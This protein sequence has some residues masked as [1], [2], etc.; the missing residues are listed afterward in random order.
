MTNSNE[1]ADVSASDLVHGGETTDQ[2]AG[3]LAQV[4]MR[5]L[6][7]RACLVALAEQSP[8]RFD[9]P[10][11]PLAQVYDMVQDKLDLASAVAGAM[12]RAIAQPWLLLASREVPLTEEW[13]EENFYP[14]LEEVEEVLTD[15][16]GCPWSRSMREAGTLMDDGIAATKV[17]IPAFAARVR[18]ILAQPAAPCRW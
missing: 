16:P 2:M 14:R 9:G 11:A 17:D 12:E 18:S 15:L 7:V 6:F 4:R 10:G 5:H 13:L 1:E 8:S 3:K